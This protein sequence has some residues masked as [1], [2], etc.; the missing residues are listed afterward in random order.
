M[1][2][3][4]LQLACHDIIKRPQL[5]RHISC[6]HFQQLLGA[7]LGSKPCS[8]CCCHNLWCRWALLGCQAISGLGCR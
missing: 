1:G 5:S 2:K 7:G 8:S 6:G 3:Q 4:T